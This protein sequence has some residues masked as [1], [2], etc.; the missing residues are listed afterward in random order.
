MIIVYDDS[1]NFYSSNNIHSPENFVSSISTYSSTQNV[2]L[3]DYCDNYEFLFELDKPENVLTKAIFDLALF[4]LIKYM[5]QNYQDAYD[6]SLYV[7]QDIEDSSWRQFT[8]EIKPGFDDFDTKQELWDNLIN[9]LDESYRKY[10]KRVDM[11]ETNTEKEAY[12]KI[13]IEVS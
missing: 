2:L 3:I 8:I 1:H 7:W 5:E 6:L 11:Q 12:R 10:I 13:S 4:N 9:I